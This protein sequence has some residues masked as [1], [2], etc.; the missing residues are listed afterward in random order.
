MYRFY[1]F[2]EIPF[3]PPGLPG[4]LNS[5][6]ANMLSFVFAFIT[7]TPA[8]VL[9]QLSNLSSLHWILHNQNGSIV[10]PG[11]VPSQVH[12]DLVKAGIITEPLLGANGVST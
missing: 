9:G 2:L 4:Q 11:S 3:N 7:F 5:S 6:G 1:G 10:V 12:L 8:F